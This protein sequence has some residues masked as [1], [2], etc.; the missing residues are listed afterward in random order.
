MANHTP[1][2]RSAWQVMATRALVY[3]LGGPVA[4]TLDALG[5]YRR[6]FHLGKA[7][8]AARRVA[9]NFGDY[10]PTKHDVLVCTYPKSGTN[11]M[12]QIAFQLIHRGQ[13]A[14]DGIHQYIP[15][16]DALYPVEAQLADETLAQRSPFGLRVIKTHLSGDHLP[17]TPQARYICVVRNPK[18]VFVSSYHFVR[19]VALGPM[20]PSVA[21][22]HETFLA[23]TFF[24]GSWVENLHNYWQLRDQPNVLVVTFEQMKADLFDIVKQLADFLAIDLS[25]QELQWVYEQSTFT[26]MKQIEHKFNP[27]PVIPWSTTEAKMIRQGQS[28]VSAE[29]LTQAQQRQIDDYC[30]AEL[31]RLGCDFPYDAVFGVG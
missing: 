22:W 26:Y 8:L 1:S 2:P 3:G 11:W 20:M 28:G 13:G 10:R 19:D 31:K 14:F 6:L 24:L 12:M 23:D 27:A 25:E 30:R 29:M 4:R 17:Y 16:P 21:T 7:Q 18:D 9:N 15:W 5:L